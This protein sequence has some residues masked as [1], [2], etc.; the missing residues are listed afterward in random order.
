VR[1]DWR[2]VE[3]SKTTLLRETRVNAKRKILKLEFVRILPI[4]CNYKSEEKE[5][6]LK[7]DNISV[8][9]EIP[10]V[11]FSGKKTCYRSVNRNKSLRAK[12]GEYG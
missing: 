11:F 2:A 6:A 3:I 9:E 10:V 7:F 12:S 5:I 8:L 1:F 4:I